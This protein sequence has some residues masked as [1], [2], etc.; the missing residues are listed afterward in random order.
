M[1]DGEGSE[2]NDLA[3]T[4]GGEA[5]VI[6][7]LVSRASLKTARRNEMPGTWVGASTWRPLTRGPLPG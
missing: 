7:V 2:P 3:A 4:G 1:D 6:T 5:H